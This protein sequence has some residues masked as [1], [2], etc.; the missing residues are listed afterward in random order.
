MGPNL[1]RY[2]H[3]TNSNLLHTH[4]ILAP[5]DIRQLSTDSLAGDVNMLVCTTEDLPARGLDLLQ[6]RY[7]S[8]I[9][10]RS[11]TLALPPASGPPQ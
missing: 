9:S 10:H 7:L 5:A 4:T 6:A 11:L 3:A 1:V 8:P 2:V